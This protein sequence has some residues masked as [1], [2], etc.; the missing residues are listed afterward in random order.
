MGALPKLLGVL[1]ELA[2][3]MKNPDVAT[4]NVELVSKV[5]AIMV[6]STGA[7]NEQEAVERVLADPQTAAE[8]NTALRDNRADLID[9]VERVN[10]ME[11]GNIK[12]ARD[13]NAEE[14]LMINTRKVKMKFWHILALLVVF[15]A[16]VA[17]GYVLK[18]SVDAGERTLVLQTLL[19]TG[20]AGV[21]LFVFG[22]SEGSKVKDV[23]NRVLPK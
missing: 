18:T 16:L 11:Q 6:G 4:R 21:M 17:I 12:A 19:L 7:A 8:V 22:S 15:A 23:M 9:I 1:P 5:G 2:A 3:T 20:F 14:P 13:F 10:A